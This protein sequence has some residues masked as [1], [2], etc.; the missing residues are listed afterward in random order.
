MKCGLEVAIT[1]KTHLSLALNWIN[2]K[3]EKRACWNWLSNCSCCRKYVPKTR[4]SKL[5][6]YF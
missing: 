2:I 3:K 6:T 4:N 1:L 5:E